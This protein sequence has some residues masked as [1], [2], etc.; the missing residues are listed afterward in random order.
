MAAI[1]ASPFQLVHQ[2]I[3]QQQNARP[4][5]PQLTPQDSNPRTR[6]FHIEFLRLIT[7]EGIVLQRSLTP[8]VRNHQAGKW[9]NLRDNAGHSPASRALSR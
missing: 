9:M 8:N 5:I 3:F 2:H 1:Y 6:K 7:T 4:S